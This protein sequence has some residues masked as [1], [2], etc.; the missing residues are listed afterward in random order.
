MSRSIGTRYY[1]RVLFSILVTVLALLIGFP[2]AY[3]IAK[4]AG[5]RTRGALF[6]FCLIPLWVSD[7]IR[8]VRLDFAVER[9]GDRIRLFAVDGACFGSG[10]ISI[11]RHYCHCR[12]GL[13]RY[14]V[15]DRTYR[16]HLGRH[17]QLN[18]RGRIQPGWR[19]HDCSAKNYRPLCKTWNC[20]WM[21]CRVHVDCWQLSDSDSSRRQEFKLVYRAD[22]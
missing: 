17:G 11:Q 2:I 10:G 12:T 5:Y 16:L 22:L 20:I 9:N 13:H 8:G 6:L 3:Y 15:Y 14:S 4:V 18:D 21:Y 1:E 7:L 19:S